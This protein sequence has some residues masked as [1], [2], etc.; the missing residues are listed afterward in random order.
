MESINR[1][2]NIKNMKEELIIQFFTLQHQIKVLHWQTKSYARH[3]AYDDVY[4][5]LGELID[6]FVEIYMGKYGRVEFSGGEG[7]ITLKNTD[8]LQLNNFLKDN[9]DWLKSLNEK[10]K[11]DNDSDLLNLRDE[12]MG[13]INK[14]RYLLTLK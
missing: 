8:S 2:L 14:L 6:N 13:E 5:S 11:S 9:I 4:S 10:L 7:S 1:T 12:M 3:K